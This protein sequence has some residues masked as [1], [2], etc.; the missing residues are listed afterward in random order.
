MNDL[1]SLTLQALPYCTL[2]WLI[3][4]KYKPIDNLENMKLN[5]K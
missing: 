4:E 1:F 2:F 5:E 3:S